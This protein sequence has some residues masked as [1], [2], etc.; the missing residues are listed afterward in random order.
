[1]QGINF[2][3]EEQMLASAAYSEL[4]LSVQSDVVQFVE[5]L[6]SGLE[7]RISWLI[8]SLFRVHL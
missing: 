5:I 3:A 1:M 2:L 6:T 7:S 8:T 4:F